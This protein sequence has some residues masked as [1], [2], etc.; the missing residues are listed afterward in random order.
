MSSDNSRLRE[1]ALF[2]RRVIAEIQRAAN[3]G[4]YEIRGF[5]AKRKMPHFDDLVKR[6]EDNHLQYR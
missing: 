2:D 1:S 6:I 4:M 3:E 5:G